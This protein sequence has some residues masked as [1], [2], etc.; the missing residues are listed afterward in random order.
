MTG[1]GFPAAFA[2]TADAIL[3]MLSPKPHAI[4]KIFSPNM[5]F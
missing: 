5:P 4:E 3:V 1:V 2:A